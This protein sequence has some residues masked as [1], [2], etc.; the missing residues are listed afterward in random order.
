M[1]LSIGA[2]RFKH[3]IVT[4]VN[5]VVVALARSYSGSNLLPCR[6]K[7]KIKAAMPIRLVC[8]I[9][10]QQ[11]LLL[12]LRQR[13]LLDAALTLLPHQLLC[14]SSKTFDEPP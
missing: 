6:L 13:L 11:L 9:R 3:D 12:L 5:G 14:L 7:L 10:Q 2:C 8:S 4:F 1:P